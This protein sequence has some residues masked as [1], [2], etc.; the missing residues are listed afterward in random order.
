MLKKKKYLI[1]VAVL[2]VFIC[3]AV[4][5]TPSMVADMVRVSLKTQ[6]GSTTYSINERDFGTDQA[7]VVTL[8]SRVSRFSSGPF[9]IMVDS[10]TTFV[11]FA[12]FVEK[13]NEECPKSKWYATYKAGPKDVNVLFDAKTHTDPHV[14]WI[15]IYEV[16]EPEHNNVQENIGTNAPNSQH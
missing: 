1:V 4:A 9:Q 7:K 13:L 5:L 16:E 14:E 8:L 12:L 2:G 6:G 3:A 15:S 11:A 10:N